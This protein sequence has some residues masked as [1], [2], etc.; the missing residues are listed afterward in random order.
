MLQILLYTTILIS[1]PNIPNISQDF[2]Q[3]IKIDKEV[4]NIPTIK[5]DKIIKPK[6]QIVEIDVVVFGAT[7]CAPCQ[8]MKKIAS[9]LY[10][11]DHLPIYYVD[12]DKR[13]DMAK[14][15]NISSVPCTIIR[16]NGIPKYKFVGII[17]E[18]QISSAIKDVIKGKQTNNSVIKIKKQQPKPIQSTKS[19]TSTSISTPIN[20]SCSS[21]SR[22]CLLFRRR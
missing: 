16:E 3:N 17:T 21:C 22:R 1:Q 7:W 6:K 15:Y 12:I 14:E 2:G 10:Y 11:D 4:N 19:I 9:K 13:K 20:T 18:E 8:V 5:I